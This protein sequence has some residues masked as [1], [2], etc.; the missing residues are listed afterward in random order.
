MEVE[1][2]GVSIPR[3]QFAEIVWDDA[4]LSGELVNHFEGS[5]FLSRLQL[6]T[7]AFRCLRTRS[8]QRGDEVHRHQGDRVYALAGLMKERPDADTTDSELQA[9]ARLSLA[10]DSDQLLERLI[11]LQPKFVGQPWQEMQ[12][13]WDIP[14]WVG[15]VPLFI[16]LIMS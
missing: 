13:A 16:F 1:P 8:L 2:S 6:A 11:C 12:D 7:L 9:F 10:N 4:A 15:P 5:L 14:L 3:K